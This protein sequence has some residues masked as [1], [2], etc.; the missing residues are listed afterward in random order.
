MRRDDILTLLFDPRFP[1]LFVLGSIV[2]ALLGNATYD[3]ILALC[4]ASLPTYGGV[5][6]VAGLIFVLLSRWFHQV[7]QVVRGKRAA[8]GSIVL[9]PEERSLPQSALVLLVG[10]GPTISKGPEWP[11]IDYHL[12]GNVLQHCWLIV[13]P[14]GQPFAKELTYMLNE[15][16]VRVDLVAISGANQAAAVYTAV[17][18]CLDAAQKRFDG[19]VA[20]N[21]TGGT[22]PMSAGAVLACHQRGVGLEYLVS[23]RK[24]A[25]EPVREVPSQMMRVRLN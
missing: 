20:V 24:P 22:K 8:A 11:I 16:N 25:G 19:Q 6:V 2:M 3:L 9:T 14:E 13:S 15:R 7:L 5:I 23:V 1:L 4:G 10:V 21:I 12:K 17:C 18:T